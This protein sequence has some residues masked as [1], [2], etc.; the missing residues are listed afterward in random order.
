MNKAA[1]PSAAANASAA[2][3]MST[4]SRVAGER[5]GNAGAVG[6][7][8]GEEEDGEE[9][10]SNSR[11]KGSAHSGLRPVDPG[12]SL[13]SKQQIELSSVLSDGLSGQFETIIKSQEEHEENEEEDLEEEAEEGEDARHAYALPRAPTVIPRALQLGIASILKRNRNLLDKT[14]MKTEIEAMSTA[15]AS[16]AAE[17]LLKIDDGSR[18]KKVKVAPHLYPSETL[19]NA[20][21]YL[22]YRMPVA[23]AA[24]ENVLSQMAR[25]ADKSW[26][27]RRFLAFGCGP[28]TATLWVQLSRA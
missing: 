12:G 1:P 22:A 7:A 25:R 18:N 23:Y 4:T 20:L 21:A 3:S 19:P 15:L 6:A 11:T 16:T 8:A 17:G 10:N 5:A 26:E 14:G 13:D 9:L 27:C 24:A 2:A 28:G